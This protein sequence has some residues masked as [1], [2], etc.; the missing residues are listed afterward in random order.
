MTLKCFENAG[1]EEGACSIGEREFSNWVSNG[2]GVSIN[3]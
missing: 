1:K 2:K 3:D